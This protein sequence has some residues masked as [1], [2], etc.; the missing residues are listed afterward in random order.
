MRFFIAIMFL[1]FFLLK[2]GAQDTLWKQFCHPKQD[3][4]TKV[5]W[6]HGET[7]TTKEGIDA[8]LE[9]FKEA[10]VGG[11]VFYDQ[12]HGTEEGAFAS[13]SPEWWKMLKYASCRAKSLGLSFEVAASNGY[14]AGGPWITPD[15]GMQQVASVEELVSIPAEKKGCISLPAYYREGF[16]DIAT[17]LIPNPAMYASVCIQ[18]ER[19]KV[20][21]N[22]ELVIN[23]DAGAPLSVSTIIYQTNPRG[24]G[25]YGSMNIPGQPQK[26]FFGAGYVDFPPIGNLEYSDDGRTWNS[27]AQL[28][29]VENIIGYKSRQRTINFPSV[30]ARYFRVRLHDWIDASSRFDKLE[31]ENVWLSGRDMID[32]WEVKTGLRSE[33]TYPHVAGGNHGALNVDDIIDITSLVDTE[34]RIDMS[35]LSN[36]KEGEYRI[37][38]I[39]Y[40]PTGGHTKHGRSRVMWKGE[41]LYA[42]TWLEA[43]V[44]N[45]RATELHYENYFKAIYDSL[46]A[47]NCAPQGF[48]MDSHE[49]GIANWTAEMPVHFKRITGYDIKPWLLALC[50]YIVGNREMTESFLRDF[51]RVIDETISEQFYGTF[52]RL[53]KND[54]VT[55]TCQ[56]MLGCVNDN[57]ASRGRSDKPQGEFW[58]YQVN[59]NYDCLDCTSA[60]HLYG[61]RIS[62]AEA[63]TDSPYFVDEKDASTEKCIEG[64]HRLLRIANLAYCKGVNEFVVCAGSFQ[65]R[66]NDKYDDSRSNHPYIF[67]RLNPA[68]P[69][70]RVHFWDYQARCAELLQTGRPVVDL[71]IYIGEDAPL[72][73]M[74]Y[75]LPVI[76]E[77]YQ[78][79]VCTLRSLKE[80]SLFDENACCP[81]YK[82]LVVQDRT[83]I[84]SEAEKWFMKLREQGMLIIRCDKGEEI[85]DIMEKAGIKP[86]ITINSADTPSDKTFF[87]HRQTKDTDIYF[88]YNHSNHDYTQSVA[89]RTNYKNIEVWNPLTLER[90]SFDGILDLRPYESTFIIAK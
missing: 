44:M 16:K 89:L 80:S 49:A 14:V 45:A 52:A 60:A 66:L 58:G 3:V 41:E 68:W 61:R 48:H 67:H 24:K 56:A 65:P 6:F 78:Y 4:R 76:P 23:Y 2:T 17:V 19:L 34:G 73:T 35:L 20:E 30:K 18:K 69:L 25:S 37:V 47:I 15:M 38:R 31:I 9:A 59:G 11:V 10:G 33:V 54:G 28:L 8:D 46:S 42:K 71:L 87:Y 84:S 1:V 13:M 55:F 36:V 7:T 21:D 86:D 40:I 22:A 64:W 90:K 62:S 85:A 79:D 82:A 5:W 70:S 72:K 57:I 83:Y 29:T 27:A 26:R 39:G 32:N 51:R 43:D 75:K 81:R 74:T 77:G 50:G 88:V 53:C 12:T 63:F